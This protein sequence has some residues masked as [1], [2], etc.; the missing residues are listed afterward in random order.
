MRPLLRVESGGDYGSNRLGDEAE[1]V[2]AC[3]SCRLDALRLLLRFEVMRDGY[4]GLL[5]ALFFGLAEFLQARKEPRHI[6]HCVLG[7]DWSRHLHL[8]VLAQQDLDLLFGT[9]RESDAHILSEVYSNDSTHVLFKV[10]KL[11]Y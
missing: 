6:F 11:F 2:K 1:D 7:G 8:S 10:S 3:S 9:S 4:D 5:C